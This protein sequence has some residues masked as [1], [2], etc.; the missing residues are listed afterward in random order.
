MKKNPYFAITLQN[1]PLPEPKVAKKYCRFCKYDIHYIDYQ[2]TDLLAKFINPEYKIL[3]PKYS[4]NC[5]KHQRKIA[6]TIKRARHMAF[7]PYLPT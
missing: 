3:A 1:D 2:H 6:R 4:G 7:L 5:P